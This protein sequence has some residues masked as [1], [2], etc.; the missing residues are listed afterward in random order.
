[1]KT[2][3]NSSYFISA[4]EHSGDIIGADLVAVL[5]TTN[6]EYGSFAFGG[7]YLK[8]AGAEI[9]FSNESYGV[10]GI[11][12]VFS[13]LPEFKQMADI[14]LGEIE[15]RRP[16]FAVLVDYPGFHFYLAERLS[17]LGIPVIQYV[18]PKLWAWGEGRANKLRSYFKLV[19][20]V[21]PFEQP[22]FKKH[23]INYQYVGS[24]HF[25]RCTQLKVNRELFGLKTEDKVLAL[26]P[27][28][29]P[30]EIAY[31][32]PYLKKI[33]PLIKK[34]IPQIKI[35]IPVADS[36]DQN[37]FKSLLPGEKEI[38]SLALHDFGS[39]Q[40]I[41]IGDF[42]FV[43]GGSLEIMA[44]ANA[45]IVASGT[46]TLECAL[47]DIP[48]CVIY[49]MSQSSYYF[50]QKSVKLRFVSLVN[51]ILNKPLVKEFIQ[52]ISIGECAEEVI[53][54]FNDN[55]RIANIKEGFDKI[56]KK[57]AQDSSF[58]AA[59]AIKDHMSF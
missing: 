4:G 53:A 2:S 55:E 5:K 12:G 26:L 25:N 27:G 33:V 7:S 28:S 6:P 35:V 51:L 10:M 34:A 18:A 45:A 37:N 58:E 21:L 43:K 47:L 41:K 30:E 15:R 56:R 42:I 1:M 23:N 52:N 13:K 32:F 22:F 9:I 14:L 49:A 17:L 29:R 36:I 31:I 40:S 57:I 39:F 59:M 50:A 19:L 20:G 16:K 44:S 8:A 3:E 24:P 46:A 38:T 48:L 11:G 54:L